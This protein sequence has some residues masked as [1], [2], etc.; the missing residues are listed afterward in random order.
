MPNKRIPLIPGETYHIFNYAVGRDLF[1]ICEDN[2]W[3][4]L[5]KI[6][7]WLLPVADIYAYSL[8]LNHFHLVLKIKSRNE[9]AGVLYTQL[10]KK[11]C[12]SRYLH[13]EDGEKQQLII[14]DLIVEQFSHCFNSYAQAYNKVYKRKGALFRQSFKRTRL[15]SRPDITKAIC[16]IHNLPV[17][18][19]L[20]LNPK[21]WRFSSYPALTGMTSTFIKCD[22][23]K[24]LFGGTEKLISTHEQW[25][26]T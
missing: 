26:K 13:I 12:V 14:R 22:E 11:Y 3:F 23:V 2:Y 4:F 19:G 18:D 20:T 6:K 8:I 21:A 16:S 9:L 15:S 1:F 17:A 5:R 25:L 10:K 24:E 7:K